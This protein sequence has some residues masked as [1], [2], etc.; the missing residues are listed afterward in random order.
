MHICKR[1]LHYFAGT[2]SYYG[3]L[4]P[5]LGNTNLFLAL[6]IWSG[7]NRRGVPCVPHRGL[8]LH[9]SACQFSIATLVGSDRSFSDLGDARA[10]SLTRVSFHFHEHW[11]RMTRLHTFLPTISSPCAAGAPPKICSLSTGGSSLK[12]SLF[13]SPHKHTLHHCNIFTANKHHRDITSWAF[14][15]QELSLSE[16]PVTFFFSS[17]M[18]SSSSSRLD[19]SPQSG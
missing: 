3:K 18:S 7:S 2:N 6:C 4:L 1:C 17:S 19:C 9:A 12:A 16:A 5:G 13:S 10:H 8:R 15:P 11:T 14:H